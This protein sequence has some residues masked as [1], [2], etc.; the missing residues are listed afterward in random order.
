VFEH[1]LDE[2]E[3]RLPIAR[4]LVDQD[5]DFG[6]ARPARRN[7]AP[8]A[9]RVYANVTRDDQ[10]LFLSDESSR[11]IS[12]VDLRQARASGF[13]GSAVVGKIPVAELP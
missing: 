2:P 11:T 10:W 3:A 13:D 5:H 12:V 7:D 8:M 4:L 6:A 1:V 9:G